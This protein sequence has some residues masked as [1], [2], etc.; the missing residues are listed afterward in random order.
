MSNLP[1]KIVLSC[2][3]IPINQTE[4][5]KNELIS[6]GM[7]L[8]GY[9]LI[10]EQGFIYLPIIKNDSY[11]LQWETTKKTFEI[12]EKNFDMHS[13][14]AQIIPVD[15][16]PYIPTSFDRV[17]NCILVKLDQAIVNFKDVIGLE[18][19]KAYKVKSVFFKLGD[20]ETEYRT[21]NWECIAGIDDP[22]VVHKMQGLRWKVNIRKVYFNTR[23]SNEYLRVASMC[24]VDDVIID[25][26]TGIGPFA[27]LCASKCPCTIQAF[28]INPLA[29]ELLR[30]NIVMNRK[31]LQGTVFPNCGDS[32]IL[33]QSLSKVNIIIMN[34]P[35][36]AIDF[37]AV[38]LDHIVDNGIIF[39][40]QFIHLSKEDK[41][42]NLDNQTEK[43]LQY[44]LHLTDK[45]KNNHI[46]WNIKGNKLRDV[47]PS[48]THVV[49]DI[50]KLVK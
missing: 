31:F 23:L 37:L 36:L 14:L 40:H 11:S 46:T 29:I 32:K 17:G 6:K 5:I 45:E 19:L 7:F 28:D 34:L 25:M 33:I 2:I 13:S 42:G 41:K 50:R 30:E 35:E 39:L 12:L 10:K 21:I 1:K 47:S 26:F 4:Q 16:H 22:I 24:N 20:V 8:K 43:L 9:R 27:L 44:I 38:A 15:L 18:L 48:K 3:K 49:W